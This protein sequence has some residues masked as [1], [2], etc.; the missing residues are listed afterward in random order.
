MATSSIR[1]A[2]ARVRQGTS[3]A[4]AFVIPAVLCVGVLMYYPMVQAV[5]ESLY[6]SSFLSPNPEFIGL[7]NYREM[8]SDATFWAVVRHSLVWTFAVVLLQNTLGLASAILLDQP[9][10]GQGFLRTIVLLPWVLPGVVAALL[11]RFMYDPQLGLVNS[12][13]VSLGLE[14]AAWLAE[15]STALGAVII[16][17]V[18]KGFPF[19]T[20]MYLAA[21]QG[22]DTQQ[23]E[24]A[25]LDGANALQRFRHVVLPAI[26][27]IARLTLLLTTLFTFNYFDMIWVTTGGGPRGATHIFPTYIFQLGFGEFRFGEAAAY[28]VVSVVILVLLAALFLRGRRAA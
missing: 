28:G 20:V 25:Q 19:S 7:E 1:P 3:L 22:V 27:N 4:I 16:A 24:A 21:L 10:F 5:V 11:W 9:S 8:L 13:F 23:L 12:L 18:W 14:R 26:S 15:P 2:R 6:T 17:A